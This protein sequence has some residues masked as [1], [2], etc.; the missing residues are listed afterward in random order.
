MTDIR[1]LKQQ[2]AAE[3]LGVTARTL[4]DW[5]DAPRNADG[6]YDGPALVAWLV[7]RHGGSDLDPVH[8]RARRDKEQAD[9]LALEN[10]LRRGE[11]A[12]LAEVARAWE[13][14]LQACRLRLLR[15]PT[16]CAAAVP[17]DQ[18][19]TVQATVRNGVHEALRELSEYEPATD[20]TQREEN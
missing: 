3:L 12:P 4:R 17:P 1:R 10:R 5:T 15:L 16:D 2:T 20:E 8:E 9:R 7:Q 19:A 13:A 18:A 14:V 11:V 6:S